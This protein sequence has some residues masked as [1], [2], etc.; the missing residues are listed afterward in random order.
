[1][2]IEK[3]ADANGDEER[4]MVLCADDFGISPGVCDAIE[5]LLEKRRLSAVSAMTGFAE[6]RQRAAGLRAA[7]AGAADVGL[8]LTLTDHD[9][10]A[11]L[12]RLAPGGALPGLSALLRAAHLRRLDAAEV[13]AEIRAQLDAFE[14]AFGGAPAFVDGHQHVHVFPVVREA[15]IAEMLRRYGASAWT[16]STA[17]PLA[18]VLRR[19]VTPFKS[20]VLAV[21]GARHARLADAAGIARNRG[22][23]GAYDL[24]ISVP[25]RDLFKKFLNDAGTHPAHPLIFCHPGRDDAALRARST[26]AAARAAEYAYFASAAFAEDCAQAGYRIAAFGAG[27]G[28]NLG[29]N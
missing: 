19:G 21:L 12:P 24:G 6:W 7:A 27:Q 2:V 29:G 28:T 25:Y 23:R 10:L 17:E 26:L 15:L 3:P 4:R 9:S 8:H 13:A 1:M 22:F 20:A 14:D 5:D 16:R 18:A 11:P